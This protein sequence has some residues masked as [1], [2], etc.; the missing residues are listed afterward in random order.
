VIVEGFGGR[1]PAEGLSG[2]AVERGCDGVEIIGAVL[3]EVGA[4]R[5]VLSEKTIGVLVGSALPRA[6]VMSRDI[7][8]SFR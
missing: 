4:F 8:D 6:V 2:S 5:E 7:A 1:F 3:G